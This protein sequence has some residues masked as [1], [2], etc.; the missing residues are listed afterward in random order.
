MGGLD[1]LQQAYAK[2]VLWANG[3]SI[4]QQTGQFPFSINND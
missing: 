2:S 4:F 1:D 3:F